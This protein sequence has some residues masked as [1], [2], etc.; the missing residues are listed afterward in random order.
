MRQQFAQS[1]LVAR[2]PPLAPKDQLAGLVELAFIALGVITAVEADAAERLLGTPAVLDIVVP[3]LRIERFDSELAVRLLA[4]G[5]PPADAIRAGE[6]IGRYQW[7]PRWL[8]DIAT[9]LYD[10]DDEMARYSA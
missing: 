7:W 6:L 2:R 3:A 8:L 1:H 9:G 5:R 4:A 10:M